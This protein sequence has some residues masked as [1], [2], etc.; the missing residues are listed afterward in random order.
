MILFQSQTGK[1][2]PTPTHIRHSRVNAVTPTHIRHSRVNAVT[3]THI[4]HSRINTVTPTHIR[5]S[6]VNTVTP[7]HIQHPRVNMVTPTHIQHSRVNTVTPTH[8]H[9]IFDGNYSYLIQSNKQ[10]F[11]TIISKKKKKNMYTSIICTL[12]ILGNSYNI[13]KLW[14]RRY[15]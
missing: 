8:I 6:R 15:R 14:F 1:P 3:P 7:T 4:R 13:F 5:H 9:I 2:A 10:V 11:K 12:Y